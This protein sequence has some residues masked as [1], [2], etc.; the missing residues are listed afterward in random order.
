MILARAGMGY[1]GVFDRGG[2]EITI[3]HIRRSRGELSGELVVNAAVVPVSRG[4]IHRASFN[5]SS[6]VTRERL[7]KTLK[8]R[9]RVDLPWADLLEEFCAAV[10]ESEREG[11]PVVTI[12]A[13]GPAPMAGYLIDPFLPEGKPTIIYA[14]GGTG[15]SYLAILCAVAVQSG[16]RVLNW[17][18]RQG[19][20]LYLD[21]ET[22]PWDI[23]ERVRRVS[24]GLGL[25]DVPPIRYRQSVGPLDESVEQIA[26]FVSDERIQLVIVDSIG[27]ASNH[28]GDRGP[29]EE[30]AVRLFTA[31]RHLKSTVLAIDHVSGDAIGSD[32]PVLKAYGSIY[33]MNLARSAWEMKG[34][35]GHAGSGHIALYHRKHN[36]TAALEPIGIRVTHDPGMVKFDAEEITEPGLVK[37]LSHTARITRELTNGAMTVNDLAD[38]LEMTADKVRTYLNRGRNGLFVKLPDGRW[39]LIHE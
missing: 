12:G 35:I 3:D 10:L 25:N 5:V 13:L 19:N 37:G 26:N 33:K 22:D 24:A 16:T 34:S 39:G 27:M 30:S 18:V 36:N 2:V 20:V 4:R 29:A 23:D 11:A 8:D 1:A 32:D 15:K 38:A 14:A 9:S 7:A 17:A 6:S 31:F 28:P 21:W